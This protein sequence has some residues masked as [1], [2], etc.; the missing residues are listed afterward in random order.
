MEAVVQCNHLVKRYGKKRVLDEINL[1][2]PANKVV[3]ILGPNGAGKSTLFRLIMGMIQPDEGSIRVFA[4]EPG[5]KINRK[6]SY[7]SDRGRWYENHRLDQAIQWAEEMWPGFDRE[8][9]WRLAEVM[10]VEKDIPA[11]G[12]SR[13]Q[14]ARLVLLL[15]IARST[16]LV[17]LDEPFSGID[18]VS[19]E[20]ILEGL[21]SDLGDEKQT[22]LISTHE[23]YETESLLDY[24]IFLNQGKVITSGET[25][26]LRRQHGSMETLY[27]KLFQ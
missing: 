27:K 26:E 8:K 24:V 4:E 17:V 25:E 16:P 23:I 5:W 2:I 6:I 12:M 9:A 19:R 15:C 3:G 11:R 22:I 20:R 14:E 7:L 18:I 10:K 13:G 1:S 21:I